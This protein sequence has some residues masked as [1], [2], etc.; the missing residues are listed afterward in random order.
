MYYIITSK[1]NYHIVTYIIFLLIP[2][3]KSALIPESIILVA[4]HDFLEIASSFSHTLIDKLYQVSICDNIT[5]TQMLNE[6]PEWGLFFSG[7]FSR[8]KMGICPEYFYVF[9]LPNDSFIPNTLT[10]QCISCS[11]ANI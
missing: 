11:F 8:S 9:L 4:Q 5:F 6:V 1:S 7:T 10:I 2:L 3:G